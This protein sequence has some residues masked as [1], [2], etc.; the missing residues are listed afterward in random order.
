MI[1]DPF[2]DHTVATAVGQRTVSSVSSS[3]RKQ[4]DREKKLEDVRTHKLVGVWLNGESL[5]Q[6]ILAVELPESEDNHAWLTP[7]F[8]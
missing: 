7:E 3:A 5:S 1:V 6:E 4:T 8:F 2:D